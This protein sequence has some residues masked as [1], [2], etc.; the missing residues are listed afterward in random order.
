M[1]VAR[2]TT[3]TFL[4][5]WVLFG[6]ILCGVCVLCN[7]YYFVSFLPPWCGGIFQSLFV[8]SICAHVSSFVCISIGQKKKLLSAR[9]F[10]HCVQV[11]NVT[12]QP[13]FKSCPFR[14]M[15]RHKF[16]E[17]T[18][19]MMTPVPLER[20]Q[21]CV[22]ARRRPLTHRIFLFIFFLFNFFFLLCFAL[23]SSPLS[24]CILC[25]LFLIALC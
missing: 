6:W 16:L 10:V 24:R 17:K 22:D 8:F 12:R 14:F 5:C 7:Y 20:R 1:C 2:I 4:F 13:Y 25:G 9:N 21:H 18:T 3:E 23:P 11:S 15:C 19:S